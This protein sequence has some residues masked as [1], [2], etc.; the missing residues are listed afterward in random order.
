MHSVYKT[1]RTKEIGREDS[2]SLFLSIQQYNVYFKDPEL[3]KVLK[4][5]HKPNTKL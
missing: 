3:K 5:K 2:H 1:D 4:D